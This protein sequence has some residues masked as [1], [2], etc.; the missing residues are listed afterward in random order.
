MKNNPIGVFDSGIGGLTVLKEIMD[1]LPNEDIVYFGDTARV[2]Y[3]PRS[4]ETVTK[5]TFQCINFL[6]TKNI[7]A[8]VIACNT[9]T[10]RSLDKAKEKYD[11]PII[12][13]VEAGA[14]T[15]A[16]ITKNKKIGV[17]GT[18]GT[19]NSR[20]YEVEIEK[21]DPKISIIG[22][23]CPLFVPI[24]EEGW[25]DTDIA[26]M[27]ATRYLQ[28][29]KNENIDALVLGCTHYPLLTNTVA[30]VMGNSV[31]LVNPARETAKDLKNVLMKEGLLREENKTPKYEYYVS[32]GPD[33][34]KQIGENFL[35]KTI[36]NINLVEI[37]R[38]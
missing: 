23:S 15:A 22:K 34:F 30:K 37:H 27:A 17:I 24:V 29:L 21:I 33:K 20:A 16:S 32:D 35:K 10:A 19:I 11:I 25:A 2:P 28:D 26:Y 4:K 13:V 31:T 38:Y 5:Y 7:K 1:V 18:E 6:L 3:G 12:G 9:A 14:K 36:D 8:I